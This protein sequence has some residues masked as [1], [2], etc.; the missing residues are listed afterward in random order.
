[1][2]TINRRDFLKKSALSG[3]FFSLDPLK[4][5]KLFALNSN[6]DR[7]IFIFSK[8]LQWLDYADMAKAALQIGFDGVDITVRPKGHVLPENVER[9]LPK[10]V[11]AVRKQGLIADTITTGF[12]KIDDPYTENIIKTASKLGIL[13]YRMG[14]I[15]YD[16]DLDI[17]QN[18]E[19]FKLR[20]QELAQMNAHYAIRGDYQNHAGTSFGAAIWDIR[21]VLQAVNSQ[22]LGAR[23]DIRHAIVEGSLS[24][25]VTLKAI[26]P[27]IRSLDIKDFNWLNDSD[28]HIIN[29]PVGEGFVNFKKY[30]ELLVDYHIRGNMTMHF[31]YPLGGAENGSQVLAVNPDVVIKA[32]KKDL[33][34]LKG[35]LKI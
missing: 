26:A 30:A 33:L 1:M 15:Q 35:F 13:Q 32:I 22:W 16:P 19:N 3:V 29:T 17:A 5:G 28:N 31:E 18:L 23:Y 8:H 4:F 20:L 34:R 27:Y 6:T 7:K 21:H 12:T 14:W 25:P 11:E 10:A 9:D 2:N 24:W